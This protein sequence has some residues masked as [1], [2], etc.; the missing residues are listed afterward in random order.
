MVTLL[1]TETVF[2]SPSLLSFTRVPSKGLGRKGRRDR[3]GVGV[4]R[5]RDRESWC[6]CLASFQLGLL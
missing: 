1:N 3:S 6:Q 4:R 5:E 2:S